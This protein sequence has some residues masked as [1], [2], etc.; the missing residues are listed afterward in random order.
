MKFYLEHPRFDPKADDDHTAR[1]SFCS[2]ELTDRRRVQ[3][4]MKGMPR[5]RL[6]SVPWPQSGEITFRQGINFRGSDVGAQSW[7]PLDCSLEFGY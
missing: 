1:C 7:D 5:A 6:P 3:A 4:V 2:G